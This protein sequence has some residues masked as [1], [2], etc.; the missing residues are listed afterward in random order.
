MCAPVDAAELSRV[1]ARIRKELPVDKLQ[2]LIVDFGCDAAEG[3]VQD[4]FFEDGSG[5]GG[6][7]RIARLHRASTRVAVR[8]IASSHYYSPG[9]T[10]FSGELPLP[11]FDAALE[12]ARVA[13]LA[14][15]HIVPL[16]APD[17]AVLLSSFSFSSNDFHLRL[18]IV[19]DAGQVTDRGFT[20]YEGSESQPEIVPMR[21]ATAAIAD[22]LA[23]AS[24][25]AVPITD[26]DRAF[27]TSRLL[28]TLASAPH[29]WVEERYV[30][31]AQKLATVDAVPALLRLLTPTEPRDA[32]QARS[33][34]A[35]L[36]AIAGITGWDPRVDPETGA[37]RS[38]D[39]AVAAA[40]AACTL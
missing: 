14:R 12:H 30:A 40:L 32:S 11:A 18:S 16:R 8:A 6:S 38:T 15:P 35:A 19:D 21:M 4:V 9:L 17:G 25:V 10:V 29:W 39:D 2:K 33:R 5:H 28:V 13:M 22:M 37:A 24:L 3:E 31:D 27:F 26:D 36:E 7:L 1:E 20:G 23:N 34:D